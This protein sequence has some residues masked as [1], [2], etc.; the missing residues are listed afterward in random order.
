MWPFPACIKMILEGKKYQRNH[1]LLGWLN[2]P[3]YPEN[4]HSFI[5]LNNDQPF[6]HRVCYIKWLFF[7]IHKRYSETN[8]VKTHRILDMKGAMENIYFSI[9]HFI[10]DEIVLR[11]LFSL[12][13]FLFFLSPHFHSLITFYLVM[14][15][16]TSTRLRKTFT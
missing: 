7:I 14:I 2:A 10:Y 16:C 6:I 12:S 13:P 9:F 15:M 11:N 3:L 5:I 4:L 1:S 8:F